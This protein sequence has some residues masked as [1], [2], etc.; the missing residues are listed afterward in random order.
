MKSSQGFE[1]VGDDY[2]PAAEHSSRGRGYAGRDYTAFP[3]NGA[4]WSQKPTIKRLS[5]QEIIDGIQYRAN[6]LHGWMTDRADKVGSHVKDQGQSEY[7]W[8]HAPTRGMEYAHFLTGADPLIFSAFDTVW[9]IK[10]GSNTGGSGIEAVGSL[11]KL[12]T[13]LESQVPPQT[14]HVHETPEIIAER[15]KHKI[16]IWEEF[17]AD[18]YVGIYSAILSF[19]AVT[20]GIPDWGHEV[21]LTALTLEGGKDFSNIREVFDNSWGVSWGKKGRG[22]LEGKKRKFDE[23]GRIATILQAAA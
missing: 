18:D 1:I 21:L 6:S 15:E 12:G 14:Y 4:S 20:V 16:V 7:C 5:E 13:C 23:A 22:V 3:L 17:E 2:M 19:Q 10:K 9:P 11:V 8:G